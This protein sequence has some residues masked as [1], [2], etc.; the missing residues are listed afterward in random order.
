M[1]N[2]PLSWSG[3][4]DAGSHK[5]QISTWP[6]WSVESNVIYMSVPG[7]ASY[8]Y[9]DFELL[10]QWRIYGD[11]ILPSQRIYISVDLKHD[12]NQFLPFLHFTKHNSLHPPMG[13]PPHPVGFI[14]LHIYTN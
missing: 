10:T 1:G 8:M 11:Y 12:K 6:D 7:L 2:C 14:L 5:L 4:I 13:H 9:L 3:L